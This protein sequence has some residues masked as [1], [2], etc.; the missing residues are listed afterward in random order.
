MPRP[1]FLHKSR[2]LEMNQCCLKTHLS[3]VPREATRLSSN[4]A[5]ALNKDLPLGVFLNPLG[6]R[7]LICK[8]PEDRGQNGMGSILLSHLQKERALPTP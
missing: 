2:L 1:L 8:V 7:V 4:P 6:L 5:S 3:P